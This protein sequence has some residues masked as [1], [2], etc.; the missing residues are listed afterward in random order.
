MKR[1]E[2]LPNVLITLCI[3]TTVL[4]LIPIIG[5]SRIPAE[6]RWGFL[7]LE[8]PFVWSVVGV[9]TSVASLL[10]S[11]FLLSSRWA[12]RASIPVKL[13][14]AAALSG[15]LCVAATYSGSAWLT[16]EYVPGANGL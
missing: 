9:C 2:E 8:P 7:S 12:C 13:I 11:T 5:L 6:Y 4:V 3:A 14:A 15:A 16:H 1:I 10:G